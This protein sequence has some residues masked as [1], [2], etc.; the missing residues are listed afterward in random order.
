MLLRG[1]AGGLLARHQAADGRAGD[2]ICPNVS[3]VLPA[4]VLQLLSGLC[5]TAAIDPLPRSEGREETKDERTFWSFSQLDFFTMHTITLRS[6]RPEQDFT[7]FQP[8]TKTFHHFFSMGVNRFYGSEVHLQ[9]G[10]HLLRRS[11][12]LPG[13]VQNLPQKRRGNFPR[14]PMKNGVAIYVLLERKTGSVHT[15]FELLQ[16]YSCFLALKINTSGGPT[17]WLDGQDSR[18]AVMWTL[19]PCLSYPMIACVPR[20]R[21]HSP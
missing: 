21:A 18:D 1:Q 3:G 17:V 12:V 14:S 9:R 16:R 10:Q 13:Q 15:K 7:M 11:A 19:S 4:V 6:L 2:V 5:G 20:H 8:P